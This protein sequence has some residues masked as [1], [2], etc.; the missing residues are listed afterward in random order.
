MKR[1]W[2]VLAMIMILGLTATGQILGRGDVTSNL[3]D[4]NTLSAALPFLIPVQNISCQAFP[5]AVTFRIYAKEAAVSAEWQETQTVN[6]SQSYNKIVL[7]GV[8]TNGLPREAFAGRLALWLG[9]QC[10]GEL[11]QG[12]L[13]MSSAPYAIKSLDSENLG[14]RPAADYALAGTSDISALTS[15]LNNE[16]SRAQMV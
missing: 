7:L 12:R 8:T 10:A 9:I 5:S 3:P 6:S 14:G 4:D 15:N 1:I 16:T 11:E 13:M 2:I